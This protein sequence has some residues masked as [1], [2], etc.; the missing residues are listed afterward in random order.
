[1]RRGPLVGL[2]ADGAGAP[3]GAGAVLGA[4]AAPRAGAG[5]CTGALRRAGALQFAAAL[6]A[7][8]LAV[9][10]TAAADAAADAVADTGPGGGALFRG[11]LRVDDVAPGN[12][13]LSGLWIAQDG[14]RVVM[15]D[16][17]S[18]MWRA[19]LLRRRGRLVGI[20]P[21]TRLKLR[22]ANGRPMYA[23]DSEG[24]HRLPDGSFA[25]SYEGFH[26]VLIHRPPDWRGEVLDKPTALTRLPRNEGI[27]ALAGAPDGTL[28]AIAEGRRHGRHP[29]WRISPEGEW[30]TLTPLAVPGGLRP[31]GADIGPDGRLYVLERGYGL[32]LRF[33]SR[34][35][36]F[37]IGPDGLEDPQTVLTTAPGRFGNL[38]G[39]SV[40]RGS[41]GRLRITMVGDDNGWTWLP[42]DLVEY[43]LPLDPPT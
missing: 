36:R 8:L 42:A 14:A 24:L 27:E 9:P 32:T 21:A 22:R 6:V 26:G 1:M 41:A 31:V 13:G 11:A 10:A 25:V 29:V 28:Y 2:T 16:D 3:R 18:E 39:I 19:D 38:E 20:G 5:R 43:A 7:L 34:V 17:R 37:A 12:A 33:R 30:T 35:R 23:L 4:G 15:L 40:W